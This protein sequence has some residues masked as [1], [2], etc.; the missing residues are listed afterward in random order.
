MHGCGGVA[1]QP[2]LLLRLL[3]A[4]LTRAHVTRLT[5]FDQLATTQEGREICAGLK[6]AAL[7]QQQAAVAMG[8]L[9]GVVQ[10]ARALAAPSPPTP[11]SLPPP[12]VD[13]AR[14]NADAGPTRTQHRPR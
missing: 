8:S 12:A 2:A 6:R 7:V 4:A 14:E 10:Q 9:H 1:G 11:N 5:F 3:T 13:G